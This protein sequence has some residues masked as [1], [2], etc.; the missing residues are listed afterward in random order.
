MATTKK[1]EKP[2]VF[3]RSQMHPELQSILENSFRMVQ[4]GEVEEHR[5]DI[6][7]IFVFLHPLTADIINS[8]P[9]L[10]VVGNCAVGYDHV[11]LAA[12]AARNVRVG[13]T[14]TVLNDATAD[15]TWAL[16]LATARRMVEGDSIS[17]GPT[18]QRFDPNWFGFQVTGMT[19]GI[20]GMGRVGLEVAK[21]AVG[22][23][24]KLLY[25]NRNPHA[26]DVEEELS[27]T[28]VPALFSLLEECDFVILAAPATAETYHLIGAK[29][30]KAMK[31]TAIL[32]NIARGSLVDTEALTRALQEGSIAAAGLDVTDPEPLPHDH[33]LLSLPNVTI[34]PH[35]GSALL[36]TRKDMVTMTVENIKAALADKEMI[37]EV[38]LQR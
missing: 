6:S 25:H 33:A 3:Q 26:R 5:E 10:K 38:K 8:F 2:L 11:D 37:N 29:E 30:L 21:R 32:I 22:F 15:L 1:A 7:A 31:K 16:L 27:A 28:F 12:C 34:S 9:N 13:Y 35:V 17:K 23:N 19:L 24:M 20:I 36:A 14:P 4:P 18:T